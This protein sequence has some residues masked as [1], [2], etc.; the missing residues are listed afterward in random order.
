MT[1][2]VDVF[3]KSVSQGIGD[4]ARIATDRRLADLETS[5]AEQRRDLRQLLDETRRWQNQRTAKMMQ[6]MVPPIQC[7][8]QWQ[9][10]TSGPRT[11]NVTSPPV[12]P[13]IQPTAPGV[14]EL[15][16][17]VP[18]Y[19]TSKQPARRKQ[20]GCQGAGCYLCGD[21]SHWKRQC[22]RLNE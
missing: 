22:P 10:V 11:P 14:A 1:L 18:D 6:R 19:R 20:Q 12:Q 4:E 8:Q 17:P 2:C 3:A 21:P 16:V 9:P 13:A 7:Y 15:G 5:V